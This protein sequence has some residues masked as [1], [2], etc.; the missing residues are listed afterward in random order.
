MFGEYLVSIF[1][2]TIIIMIDY[3][4]ELEMVT[5]IFYWFSKEF[6]HT[7]DLLSVNAVFSAIFHYFST[8]YY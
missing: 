7:D 2:D 1:Y 3:F 5:H 6:T 8:A 4:Y